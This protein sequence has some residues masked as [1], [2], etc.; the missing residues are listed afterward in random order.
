V[1]TSSSWKIEESQP[2]HTQA[3]VLADVLLA[4]GVMQNVVLSVFQI[5]HGLLR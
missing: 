5:A 3:A 2:E 1:A 4:T